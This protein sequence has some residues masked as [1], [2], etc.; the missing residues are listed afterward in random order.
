MP[1]L[2]SS[3][4]R[5]TGNSSNGYCS[6]QLSMGQQCGGE[7]GNIQYNCAGS[8]A[9]QDQAFAGCACGG[10]SCSRISKFCW[11]CAQ[12]AESSESVWNNGPS[13][14]S[15]LVCPVSKDANGYNSYDWPCLLR[16]AVMFYDGQRSGKV[17]SNNTMKWRGDA[18]MQDVANG[19]ALIGGF[20]DAGGMLQYWACILP[21]CLPLI[22]KSSFIGQHSAWMGVV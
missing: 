7:L 15:P 5:G 1:R 13:D 16:T 21:Y 22:C 8:K 20:Y 3:C 14:N 2:C 6:S 18:S 19:K 4:D 10:G 9:C 17:S 12:N 11:S